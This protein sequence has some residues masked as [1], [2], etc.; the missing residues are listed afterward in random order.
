MSTSMIIRNQPPLRYIRYGDLNIGSIISGLDY[1][2]DGL[3]G[4][5]PFVNASFH[6][7][8]AIAYAIDE[9][10]K[11][12]EILPN[13]TLGFVILDDCMKETT[14]TIQRS[15]ST[16]NKT[17]SASGIDAEFCDEDFDILPSYDVVGVIGCLRSSSSSSASMVLGPAQLPL[18]S[19]TSTSE[20]LNNKELYPYFM[21]VVPSDN[22][23]VD[24]QVALI[25]HFGWSYISVVYDEGTFGENAFQALR[26][27]LASLEKVCIATSHQIFQKSRYEDFVRIMAD[28]ELHKNARVV[29]SYTDPPSV[30]QLLKA[31]H[32]QGTAG[33]FIWMS[34]ESWKAALGDTNDED[35]IRAAA[36]CLVFGFQAL[37]SPPYNKHV[38]RMTPS[39]NQNP[40]FTRFWELTFKCSVTDPA[41]I[42]AHKV[43]SLPGATT[44]TYANN[45][46]EAV[47]TYAHGIQAL[48][49]SKCPNATGQDIKQCITGPDLLQTMRK[50]KFHGPTGEI[51]FDQTGSIL[52]SVDY[53]GLNITPVAI[54][55]SGKG[56]MFYL[57][58]VS[59]EHIDQRGFV[60]GVPESV[61]SKPCRS[62]Q[63]II[64]KEVVCC[65]ECR[66]CRANEILVNDFTDCFLCPLLEWPDPQTNFTICEAIAPDYPQGSDPVVILCQIL[67]AVGVA[68]VVMVT[69]T[70]VR[71]RNAS[72]IKAS[73]RELSCLQLLAILLGYL[74]MPVLTVKP[75]NQVCSGSFFLYCLSFTWV[76]APLLVK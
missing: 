30:L 74:T 35:L 46:Y 50:L 26:T 76:Y 63:F 27:K 51:E 49:N 67:A 75:S 16:D 17:C 59:F 43:E 73:G 57:R 62:G 31:S 69:M 10:N 8:E 28:L 60:D 53:R 42:S 20:I 66:S 65:W 48:V 56:K 13:V 9:V 70:L 32:A 6:F 40:W 21:R 68:L 41:C 61:C 23:L 18:V 54:F 14:A 44:F 72:V 39:N 5:K 19:F 2:V 15:E 1:S 7:S 47:L 64:A 12:K 11:N 22:S 71:Y 38:L 29:I 52:P 55:Y 58:N 45:A 24:A 36:G 34:N 25:R 33:T 4:N 37:V 3:C